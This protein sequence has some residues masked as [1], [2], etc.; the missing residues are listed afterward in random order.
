MTTSNLY[1][2]VDKIQNVFLSPIQ[3]LLENWNNIHGLTFLNESKISDLEWAGYPGQ[4][5]IKFDS[6]DILNYT[7]DPI[8]FD[9]SKNN[10]KSKVANERWKKENEILTF[11]GNE[12]KLDDKTKISLQNAKLSLTETQS[13][14]WK[15][16]NGFSTLTHTQLSDLCNFT[17]N[18]INQCFNEEMRVCD[19][20]SSVTTLEQLISLDLSCNWPSTEYLP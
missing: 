3:E 13:I 1:V 11:E 9:I 10:I 2:L 4:G 6:V 7:Y 19:L 15:F 16:R 14:Q 12:L 17:F 8:W 20:V 5:W 18:Y